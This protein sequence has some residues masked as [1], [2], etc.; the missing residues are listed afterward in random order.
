MLETSF[1][2]S[3]WR[4]N[5]MSAAKQFSSL[6]YTMKWWF[7]IFH[8]SQVC[9]EFWKNKNKNKTISPDILG[10]KIAEL[11]FVKDFQL[12][13]STRVIPPKCLI[14]HRSWWTQI[15]WIKKYFILIT[16]GQNQNKN[17]FYCSW[18]LGQKMWSC[19][20]TITYIR[21]SFFWWTY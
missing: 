5:I 2:L 8:N 1:F 12:C 16:S 6:N 20:E 14:R 4:K 17:N 18:D 10:W 13:S 15:F 9:D 3:T 21:C 7:N 11:S 19:S